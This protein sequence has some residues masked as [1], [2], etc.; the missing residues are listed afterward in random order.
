MKLKVTVAL[1][2]LSAFLSSCA[3]QKARQAITD[4]Q[5]QIALYNFPLRGAPRTKLPFF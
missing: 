5:R 4:Q 2:S 3:T 1:L